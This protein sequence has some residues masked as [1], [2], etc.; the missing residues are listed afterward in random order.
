M[1]KRL[2][3]MGVSLVFCSDLKEQLVLCDED[4]ARGRIKLTFIT[5]PFIR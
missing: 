4:Y 3:L 5:D 1:V 2:N